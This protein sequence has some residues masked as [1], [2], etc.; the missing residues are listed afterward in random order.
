M[1]ITVLLPSSGEDMYL[2]AKYIL[3]REDAQQ[4]SGF[5]SGRTI[6]TGKVKPPEKLSKKII[7]KK[8]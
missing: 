2:I 3:I 1:I 6:K 7:H 8:K 5:V 4:I